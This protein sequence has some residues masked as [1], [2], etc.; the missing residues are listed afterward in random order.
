MKVY[1]TARDIVQILAEEL[2]ASDPKKYGH[3]DATEVTKDYMLIFTGAIGLAE[4]YHA[5]WPIEHATEAA[6]RLVGE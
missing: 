6:R 2:L 5:I 3:L 1:D 4:I